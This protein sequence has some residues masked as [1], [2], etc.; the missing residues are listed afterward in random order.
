MYSTCCYCSYR[1]Q[2]A[3][4]PD[5]RN[6]GYWLLCCTACSQSVYIGCA[7]ALVMHDVV[8]GFPSV[9]QHRWRQVGHGV[10][11]KFGKD[12]SDLLCSIDSGKP[13]AAVPVFPLAI[14]C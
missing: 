6:C 4:S 9:P 2:Q 14:L 3:R 11:E 8:V 13:V 5:S 12:L 1:S 10:G 7:V